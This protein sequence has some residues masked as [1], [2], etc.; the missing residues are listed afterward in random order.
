[1]TSLVTAWPPVPANLALNAGDVHVWCAFLDRAPV[2]LER[3]W[4]TLSAEEKARA[5]RF[6]FERDKNHFIVARGVLRTILGR[7]LDVAPAE[8]A[9]AYGEHGKPELAS[10]FASSTL[11]FNLSHAQG[12]ALYAFGF[13]RALGIDVEKIRFLDDAVPIAARFFSA[14]ES[15]VFRAVPDEKKPEAFFNC[16]TRK[17]A[18]IKAIGEGLSCPLDAFDVSLAPGETARLLQIRGSEEAAARWTLY[19]LTP[20]TGYVG[21]VVIEGSH[22]QLSCWQWLQE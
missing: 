15:S 9:F 20:A 18:Y 11:Q 14:W 6:Y 5:N 16:W 12:V 8:I 13:G 22:C 4:Q 19:T 2:Q 21:A 1:M 10:S 3:L 7:Y 17:E